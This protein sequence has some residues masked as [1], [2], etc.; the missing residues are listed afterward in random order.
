M[1]FCVK[2]IRKYEDLNS[3]QRKEIEYDMVKHT[4][5]VLDMY[6]KLFPVKRQQSKYQYSQHTNCIFCN[7]TDKLEYH[8]II[9]VKYGGSSELSNIA[10]LCIAC[11]DK[12]H[13]FQD[14][15][16]KHVIDTTR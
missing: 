12:L 3:I 16:I 9:P 10:S 5:Y 1:Y 4:E 2:Q 14:K 13:H 8:H 7:S 15:A 6:F 11:H